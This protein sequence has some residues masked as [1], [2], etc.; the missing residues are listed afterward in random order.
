MRRALPFATVAL[1]IF[2]VLEPLVP[3]AAMAAGDAAAHS[4]GLFLWIS[5]ILT[6]LVTPPMLTLLIRRATPRSA[7]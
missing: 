5:V 7:G 1:L 3:A 4:A 2:A 6:T